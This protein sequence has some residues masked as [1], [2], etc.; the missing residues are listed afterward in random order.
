MNQEPNNLN[1][2]NFNTQ[3]NNGIPNNPPLQNNNTFNQGMQQSTNVNQPTFNP[4]PQPTPSFQQPI[5]QMNMQQPTPQS[6]NTFESGNA[7]NQSFNSKPP[8]KMNLGLIIG[9]VVVV[10]VI[11][12]G[13]ILLFNNINN[14]N[15][16][17]S[18]SENNTINN[19]SQNNNNDSQNNNKAIT[20][21]SWKDF[22]IS[23]DNHIITMGM[24]VN[25]I[26]T[27]GFTPISK[28]Y[29][30]ILEKGHSVNTEMEYKGKNGNN[31]VFYPE[32]YNA[33]DT[34]KSVKETEMSY[35]EINI[36]FIKNTDV[37]LPGGIL[38]NENTSIEE[39]VDSMGNYTKNIARGYYWEDEKSSHIYVHFDTDGKLSSVQYSYNVSLN[40][41]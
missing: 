4:Q 2:N 39:I 30:T 17:G 40:M 27:Y 31:I 22:V 9:I 28:N 35:F 38:L 23:I 16:S 34:P 11:G 26:E 36:D 18:S 13:G 32:V 6:M 20:D 7:N 29:D 10:A 5:N 8:K 37:R 25:S 14:D 12:I 33:Y 3:G 15:N 24:K 19:N 1:P 21:Y 41:E